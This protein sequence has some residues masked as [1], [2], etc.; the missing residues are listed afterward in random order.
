VRTILIVSMFA[1]AVSGCGWTGPRDR[2][3]TPAERLVAARGAG[4]AEEPELAPPGRIATS[5]PATTTAP[6]TADTVETSVLQVNAAFLTAEAVLQRADRALRETAAAGGTPDQ[7]AANLRGVIRDEIRRQVE[8]ILLLTEA[9]DRLDENTTKAI[10]KHVLEEY[11]TA[12]AEAGGSRTALE[13]KLKRQGADLATWLADLRGTMIIQVYGQ[14]QLSSQ[15]HVTREMM[16]R[17]YQKHAAK[18]DTR[19]RVKMQIILVEPRAFLPDNALPT[20]SERRQG[21]A[22]A[23]ARIDKAA[24]EVRAGKDFAEVAKAHSTGPMA[25]AGGVWP[26]MDVGSFRAEQVEQAACRQKVGEVAGP[27]ETDQGFYLVKTLA[28]T[29][30]GHR[31][32]AEVQDEIRDA[33]RRRQYE[34]LTEEYLG[35]LRRQARIVGLEA[36]ERTVLDRAARKLF[37]AAPAKE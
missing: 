8:R 18:Y 22:K 11:N 2:E 21:S 30:G 6:H 19:D 20:A 27:I 29:P 37:E 32:F 31:P 17:Y 7:V 34:R 1:A 15:I 5:P 3:M 9:R 28:H 10:E 24:A 36:F 23:K 26:E 16:W 12:L 33:L 4:P 25:S 14:R 13:E 35:K